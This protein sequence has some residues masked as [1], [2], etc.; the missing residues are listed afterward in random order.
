[1]FDIN[2][3]PE[4]FKAHSQDLCSE[5]TVVRRCNRVD[6]GP[7]QGSGRMLPRSP[8]ALWQGFLPRYLVPNLKYSDS[9][10]KSPVED[11]VSISALR[12]PSRVLL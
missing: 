12:S 10:R 8:E 2:A 6:E 4:L 5:R 1:M 7:L 11:V 3:L 9:S